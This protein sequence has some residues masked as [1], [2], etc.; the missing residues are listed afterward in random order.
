METRARDLTKE[1]LRTVI[2]PAG[3]FAVGRRLAD[4]ELEKLG[5][6]VTVVHRRGIHEPPEPGLVLEAGDVIILHGRQSRLKRAEGHL[7]RGW[8]E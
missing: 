3:A 5:V 2:L 6:L 7:L 8:T 4:L 1:H